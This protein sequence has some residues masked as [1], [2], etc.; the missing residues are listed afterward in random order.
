MSLRPLKVL[1]SWSFSRYS[2]YQTC[3]LKAKL[4]HLDKL[5]EPSSAPMERGAAIAKLCEAYVKGHDEQGNKVSTKLPEELKGFAPEFRLLRK[6]YAKAAQKEVIVED[7]WAFRKDWTKTTWDDWNGCWLRVKLD[8][9]TF[10]DGGETILVTDWKTGKYRPEEV[11]KYAEQ[12]E[13]YALA[14]LILHPHVKTVKARLGFLDH[15]VFHPA[16]EDT[17]ERDRFTFT[18]ADVPRLKAEWL[19]RVLPMMSD[20]VFAPRPNRWCSFCHF[21]KSNT[22][23]RGGPEL[24]QY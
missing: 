15:D 2:D 19:R 6:R 13:L 24:C 3:P 4:K 12:L 21:R 18:Q 9:A 14:G 16:A 23:A 8:V 11:E 17:K 7:T 10:E 5:K 20:T 1:T 22:L